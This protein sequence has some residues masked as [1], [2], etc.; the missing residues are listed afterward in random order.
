MKMASHSIKLPSYKK[1][2]VGSTMLHV[3]AALL[4]GTALYVFIIDSQILI[5][6]T[7]AFCLSITCE[8]ICLALRKRPILPNIMDGSIVLA[9]WLLVLCV[10]QSLP[11]WQ[12]CVGVVILVTLGKHVFG[13][14]GQNPFNPAMVAY[15]ALLI[16]F[17]V[18]M[19]SWN[20]HSANTLVTEPPVTSQLLH[21]EHWDA[22]SGATSLDKIRQLKRSDDIIKDANTAE[23]TQRIQEHYLGSRWSLIALA[24][25]AGGLYLMLVKVITWHIPVSI[26]ITVLILYAFS[27]ALGHA[28]LLSPLSIVLSGA[29]TLGA[30]FI[31][32]DPVSGPNS[33]AGQ[34]IFGVAI[35]IFTVIIREFSAYPEGFA[36]AV[37][38]MNMC[39]PLIDYVSSRK[40]AR[41]KTASKTS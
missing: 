24:W 25:L 27:D 5:N 30:F 8:A 37:L 36:F 3:M 14:L 22:L 35:G 26:T 12:L 31:A 40:Y 16:S 28:T 7:I 17:P 4:P 32:T 15:A 21:I 10:P 38:L 33:R 11:I 2:S 23:T 9:T 29:I 6:L 34:L 41:T 20:H 1:P 13:G 39:V 19:T 18:T